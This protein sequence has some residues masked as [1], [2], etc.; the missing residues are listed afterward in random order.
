MN[1][2]AYVTFDEESGAGAEFEG[3]LAI[4]PAEEEFVQIHSHA[5]GACNMVMIPRERIKM[6]LV[7]TIHD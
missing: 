7:Q 4:Q 1:I 6:I 5:D 3:V 2:T